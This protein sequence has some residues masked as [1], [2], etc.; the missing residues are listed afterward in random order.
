MEQMK[1]FIIHVVCSR[2][3][4]QF[5]DSLWAFMTIITKSYN[6]RSLLYYMTTRGVHQRLRP[7][8]PLVFTLHHILTPPIP[9]RRRSRFWNE[10]PQTRQASNHDGYIS[11]NQLSPL[12]PSVL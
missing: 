8:G 2:K 5:R 4:E 3:S 11:I 7:K 1:P 12:K 10:E 6:A 9:P